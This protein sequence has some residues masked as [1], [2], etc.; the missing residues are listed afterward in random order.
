MKTSRNGNNKKTFSRYMQEKLAVTILVIT[1]ALFGLVVVLY[2][3]MNEKNEEYT[4]I[5]LNQHSS[6]DSRTLPY[7]RGDIVDRNGTYLATSEKVYNLILDP[8]QINQDQNKYLEATLTALTEVF[9]FD[10]ADLTR[11]INENPDSYYIRYARQLSADQKEAF[12]AKETE[13]AD[14]YA[15]EK[16]KQKVGGVWFEEE[17][18]RI[19]PYDSLACNVVGFSFDN[20]KQGSGGI[21]QYY[22]DQLIG[23]N[24]REYGYL[25]DESN[26][27]R[28][29]KPA[30]NG[31]TIVSTI[32]ANIQKITEKYID[33][34]M[35][36]I[37]SKTA[38]AIVMD[39][40][41]GEVLAMASNRRFDLNNP[42]DL[43][44]YYTQ[45]EI[46]A[47]TDEEKSDAWN[48]MWRN[49]CVSDSF[50]PGSPA[51]AMTVAAC[52]EEGVINQNTTFV[53]D[54]GYDVGG[55][56]IK[57]VSIFGHGTLTLAQTLMKSCNDA[58]MQM[59]ALLGIER[60]CKYQE[61]FGMG[62]KTGI[63]LP[64]EAD[65]SGLI[66]T[67]D[68]MGPTDLATNSFGQSYN[69]TM[70]QMAAA[71][72]S[73]ING[74]SYYQPHVVKQILNEQGN[75]VKK[76]EPTILRETISQATSD[77]VRYAL[78]ETVDNEEGT[79]KAARVAGYKVGGKTGTAQKIP[80]S[81]NNYLLSFAG[82]A[83]ADDPQVLVYVVIDTPNLPGKEQAHSTF[84]TEVFQKILAE[85]LPYMNVFPDT[86]VEA[87]DESLSV[88]EEGITNNNQGG[89]ET[90]GE[91]EETA[92]GETGESTAEA[93]TDENGETIP[94]TE[95]PGDEVIPYDD[96][97]GLP[98]NVA[99][100]GAA[101]TSAGPQGTGTSE[102]PQGAGGGTPVSG[103]ASGAGGSSAGVNGGTG[104]GGTSGGTS[105]DAQE[106]SAGSIEPSSGAVANEPAPGPGEASPGE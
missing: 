6:Y 21:E 54:G 53:C 99:G 39:P 28:V 9:G 96:G 61:I 15:K 98:D 75:V 100:G 43:S 85:I 52:L 14:Q 17:Y 11:V 65:T 24:G 30:E 79:G 90:S 13:L 31:N 16:K 50:E 57:C 74:G 76:V 70:I 58:M 44:A 101:G 72:S 51:K 104:G 94:E 77:F 19:Y 97:L 35:N 33:E 5:V 95:N 55:Y 22:N 41:S 46:D 89:F 62:Q 25:D 18:R 71:F 4:E 64:G 92:E 8:N 63:D 34:W 86:E 105:A 12:E 26:M 80:R 83:P 48:T 49:F 88:Q 87:E 91:T 84:A 82:F 81:A 37:G 73:V 10:R 56:R 93:P 106:T 20:G 29:I 103:T 60:F 36:G 59:S 23:N 102:D 45:A 40:N 42:R 67:A 66:Y 1:L 78:F 32:D 3:M 47:M 27:E 2:Q 7:R 69:C 38:A 68:R